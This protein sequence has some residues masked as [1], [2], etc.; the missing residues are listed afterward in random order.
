MTRKNE[1]DRR[2]R[3][4]TL[5]ATIEQQRVDILLAAERWRDAAGP[6]ETG[7]QMAYRYRTPALTLGGLMLLPL[8][9]RPGK[10]LKLGRRL[11]FGALT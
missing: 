10:A 8:L 3:K 5:E 11:V 6:L 9:R 2:E 7:W 1:A 4:A